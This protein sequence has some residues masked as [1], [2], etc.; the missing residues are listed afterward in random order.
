[1]GGGGGRN[2]RE[3]EREVCRLDYNGGMAMNYVLHVLHLRTWVESGL[4]A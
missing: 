1:M 4:S 3:G 2:K